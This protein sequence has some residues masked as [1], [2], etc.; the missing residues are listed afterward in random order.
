[1]PHSLKKFVC[2]ILAILIYL[3]FSR[4]AGLLHKLGWH[5]T[6]KKIPL[7]PYYNK[8]FYN[9]RND[10]LDRF[11]T[12]LEQRFY[13]RGRGDDEGSRFNR[14]LILVSTVPFGMRWGRRFKA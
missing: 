13:V 8:P 1:M 10:C 2:D 11:G 12:K 9:L 6:A 3:P 7:E 14:R 4:F 5:K